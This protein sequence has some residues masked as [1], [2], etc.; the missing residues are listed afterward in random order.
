MN[1]RTINVPIDKAKPTD[2]KKW[3]EIKAYSKK[4]K[5]QQKSAYKII[6]EL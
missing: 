3:Y 5:G 1:I 6:K 4:V 2:I